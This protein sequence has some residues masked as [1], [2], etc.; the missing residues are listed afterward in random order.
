MRV[1]VCKHCLKA[2]FPTAAAATAAVIL[3]K[4]WL[5]FSQLGI[6]NKN[7]GVSSRGESILCMPYVL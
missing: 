2:P 1:C 7:G 5:S 6:A 3:S 4:Y